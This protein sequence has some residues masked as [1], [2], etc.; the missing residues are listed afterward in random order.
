LLP[1]V[2]EV[3]KIEFAEEPDYGKLKFMLSKALLQVDGIPDFIFDW[4]LIP[5][6]VMMEI[7][8]K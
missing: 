8:I 3:F 6:P 2:D 4:S 7:D 5:V 1:F